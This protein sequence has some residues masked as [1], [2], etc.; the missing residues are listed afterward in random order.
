MRSNKGMTL[1]EMVFTLT[2]VVFLVSSIFLI[3]IVTLRGWDQLGNRTDV[4]EKL[5]FALERVVRDVREANA[6]SVADHALRF[7]IRESGTDNSY[8]YYLHNA[9]DPW[10]PDYD[11][12]TYDLRRATLTAAGGAGIADDTF[13]YGGGDVI[14]IALEPPSTNTSIT[15][16]GSYGI[17]KLGATEGDETLTVRGNVRPRNV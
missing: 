9:S 1:F 14:A 3:Y 16:S 13:T 12:S 10:V 8:I 5:H 7:T 11:E 15:S 17:V 4:D 6:I 2:L